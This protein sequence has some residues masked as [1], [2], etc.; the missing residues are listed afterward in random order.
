M[1][2]IAAISLVAVAL[3]AIQAELAVNTTFLTLVSAGYGLTFSG[4]LVLGGR[5]AD[6]W[7]HRRAFTLGLVVFGLASLAGLWSPG[8]W[9]L[10]VARFVQGAGAALV[11]PAA[12]A[13]A[14][15]LFPEPH[16][17]ERAL[18]AWGGLSATGAVVG[19]LLSGV[20]V[21]ALGWRWVFALPAAV[22]VV[23]LAQTPALLPPGRRTSSVRLD[24]PGAVLLTAGL[25]ALTYGVLTVTG[26][27]TETGPDPGWTFTLAGFLLLVAFVA[28][29]ARTAE[30]LVP[31]GFFRGRQRLISL[32]VIVLAAATSAAANFFLSLYL[33]QVRALTPLQTSAC[34]LPM[35][36]I[37]GTGP[38]AGRWVRRTGSRGVTATGVGLTGLSLALLGL[39]MGSGVSAGLWLGLLL[40]PVGLGLAFSG[41][42]VAALSDVPAQERGL[43]GGVVN[44]GMEVG[45]TV[46]L[47]ALV[48]V[49]RIR[50]TDLVQQGLPWT[51]A[52]AGG[53][54]WALYSMSL[55]FAGLGVVLVVSSLKGSSKAPPPSTAGKE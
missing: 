35:L 22:A 42:T 26:G 28:V 1:T 33:Q 10:L 49:S 50:Y 25:S 9:V 37:G 40:F 54:A 15:Q 30:P 41:A 6:A 43:A 12:L 51:L 14:G 23:A 47:A 44:T 16:E 13:L 17:R 38:L 36:L 18:A 55:A 5:L 34:F 53:Y 19:M 29:E 7:G 8:L 31:L 2:L 48:A 45:P 21:G 4:L 39:G 24:V 11:A 27:S 3:P 46:G 32:T 52:L 20:V